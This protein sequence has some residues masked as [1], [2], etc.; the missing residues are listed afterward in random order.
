[1]TWYV[2][3]P[4]YGMG[5]YESEAEA[6]KAAEDL[7]AEFREAAHSDGWPEAISDLEW[8]ELLPKQTVRVSTLPCEPGGEFDEWWNCELVDSLVG[9]PWLRDAAIALGEVAPDGTPLALT[10]TQALQ[11]IGEAIR[12]AS[13]ELHPEGP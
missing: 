12:R 6:R 4:V 3:D 1:M 10:W 11:R 13:A 2:N 5:V 8:G 9:P 7:L